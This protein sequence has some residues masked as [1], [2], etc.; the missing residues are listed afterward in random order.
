MD[1]K[2]GA[3][4][5][6]VEMDED[7]G[8]EDG[9][10]ASSS[11]GLAGVQLPPF[12][13]KTYEMV[14]DEATAGMI[15]WNAD[16]ASFT[17][18]E[19]AAFARDML[20]KFFKHSNFSS[21]VRQLNTYGFRKVDTDKWSFAHESFRRGRRDLLG[22]I[23]RRRAAAAD[24]GGARQAGA[25]V[26]T[27]QTVIEVGKIGGVETEIEQLKRD[28]AI[29]MM[30]LVKVR[31]QQQQMQDMMD[32]YSQRLERQ[33]LIASNVMGLLKGA[34]ENPAIIAKLMS[35]V[36]SGSGRVRKRR[37]LDS[38]GGGPPSHVEVG[39]DGPTAEDVGMAI[40]LRSPQA[41]QLG[42]PPSLN[43]PGPPPI[44][45]PSDTMMRMSTSELIGDI[46]ATGLLNDDPGLLN[47]DPELPA[48]ADGAGRIVEADGF[49]A[50]MSDKDLSD[51]MQL[52]ENS[53]MEG[54]LTG[55]EMSDLLQNF[56]S[57]SFR[58]Q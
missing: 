10:G 47:D 8:R 29:L 34:A 44:L 58:V 1:A 56:N 12:I 28:K 17:V 21:F 37:Q 25:V 31:N 4:V 38:D 15:A 23:H 39:G 45:S 7:G 24:K 30:E 40:T 57:D 18:W 49:E 22:E 6:V 48:D 54:S 55:A 46:A 53:D 9:A 14:E 3:G 52:F 41:P 43:I 51:M 5:K 27:G 26:P 13:T 50:P 16:G 32:V 19:P 42:K 33:E 20:P 35:K 11:R 36:R 2:G